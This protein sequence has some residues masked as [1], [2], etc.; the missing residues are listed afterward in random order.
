MVSARRLRPPPPGWSVW[1][2]RSMVLLAGAEL[3]HARRNP[4]GVGFAI[5][6]AICWA[7]GPTIYK[8]DP[9]AMPITT[10]TA[11]QALIGGVPVALAGMAWRPWIGALSA[12]GRCLG[13]W[14]CGS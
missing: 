13:F 2:R 6:A 12:S 8:R 4:A 9:L 5:A 11:W 1:P 10:Q 7:A 3:G 14:H